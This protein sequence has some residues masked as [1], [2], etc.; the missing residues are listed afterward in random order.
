MPSDID[1]GPLPEDC[2]PWTPRPVRELPRS[3]NPSAR[4]LRKDRMICFEYGTG[5][6]AEVMCDVFS[7]LNAQAYAQDHLFWKGQDG[8]RIPYGGGSEC[9]QPLTADLVECHVDVNDP[10][11]NTVEQVTISCR[12]DVRCG[13]RPGCCS[14][15][16]RKR[17]FI[18]DRKLTWQE[19]A[20]FEA[21]RCDRL[22]KR[23]KLCGR[24]CA[25]PTYAG[26]CAPWWDF[27]DPAS[28]AGKAL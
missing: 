4:D 24:Y 9:R 11:M 21:E 28:C 27:T 26:Q 16:G 22:R 17:T 18:P 6:A 23:S 10:D 25:D 12:G 13:G 8:H 14:V 20:T 7:E 3:E 19:K 2:K 15:T 5:D 1:L